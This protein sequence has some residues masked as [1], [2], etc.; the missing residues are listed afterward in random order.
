MCLN[1]GLFWGII[2]IVLGAA[3]L[4]KHLFNLDFPVVKVVFGVALILI[5]L[6]VLVF[7]GS[8]KCF[9]TSDKNNVVFGEKNMYYT[10]DNNEYNAVFS[11]SVLDLSNIPQS[12][13][14][15]IKVSCV[16]GSIKIIINQKT[17]LIIDSDVVFGSISNP[18]EN[19]V[20]DSNQIIIKMKAEAVFGSIKIV[21]E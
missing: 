7:K 11:S 5:G 15:R 9:T 20:S 21:R 2:I 17:K 6:K 18:D 3:I 16:F 10:A 12:N 19:T 13:E 4:I 14:N 1:S 8:D